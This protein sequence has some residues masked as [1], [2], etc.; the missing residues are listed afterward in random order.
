MLK[1]YGNNHIKDIVANMIQKGREP[2]SIMIYGDKGLGKKT[3][4]RYIAAS[5]MCKE[6]SGVPCGKCKSCRMMAENA[7]PDYI[8]AKA[9]SSGNYIIDESIRPI[10]Y[11][12][13]IKPNE[14]NIK[15]YVI[16]DLDRSVITNVQAQNILLKIIEEP[17]AHAVIIITATGKENF[18]PTVISRVVSFGMTPVTANESLACL[19]ER[20]ADKPPHEIADA[21]KT[22]KGNIGRCI[23]R[24]EK[25][26]FYKAAENA[27]D[28]AKAFIRADEY[29]LLQV[30][31]SCA[32]SRD[33]FYQS[34]VLFGEIIRDSCAVRL[35][36][37]NLIGCD[38]EL[39]R[40]IS[41]KLSVSR[42]VRL[43]DM[44]SKYSLRIKSNGSLSLA[45]NSLAG[46]LLTV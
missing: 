7:H 22:G 5:L 6:R 34:L 9:N 44:V 40:A 2:H 8:E 25:D 14:G 36:G 16:P 35:G 28:I 42:S 26:S 11:D 38:D 32:G 41:Q 23:R 18:L 30:L 31:T 19:Q 45:A 27:K 15:V 12:A 10:V 43:Y 46:Q 39:S 1:I 20:F 4:A 3:M 24:L 33:V 17:P 21:V 37:E 13:S 29:K